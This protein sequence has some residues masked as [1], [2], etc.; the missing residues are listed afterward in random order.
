MMPGRTQSARSRGAQSAGE[1]QRRR[2]VG[3]AS[4]R[5]AGRAWRPRR[6]PAARRCRAAPSAS[7]KCVISVISSTCGSAFSRVQAARKACG[8]EAEPVHAAVHLQEDAVRRV[9]LVRG[10][11]VDLLVAVHHVPQVQ[12]RAQ[13]QVAR[14][15]AAFEQQDR[16]APAERAHALG[17][18]QVEQR[19]AVGAAQPGEDALDAVAV[20]IGLDDRPDPASG[21]ARAGARRLCASASVWISGFDRARHGRVASTPRTGRSAHAASAPRR[22][23]RAADRRKKPHAINRCPLGD[24]VHPGHRCCATTDASQ[25]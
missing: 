1:A 25:R 15:E 10:Q 12:A 5:P 19:E 13:L 18:V 24:S 23:C 2:A 22:C 7:V 14:L 8:R 4:A 17:L 9:R 3:T 6:R 20:G 16:A 21:A 11:H